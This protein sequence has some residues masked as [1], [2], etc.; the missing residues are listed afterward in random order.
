MTKH[1]EITAD[2]VSLSQIEKVA[3]AET[4]VSEHNPRFAEP[5]DPEDAQELA[6]TMVASGLIQNLSGLRD[7]AGK[8]GIVAGRRRWHA[9][10]IAV[11]ERPELA[12]IDVKVTDDLQT[13]LSWA[14]LENTKREEMDKVDEIRAYKASR[15]EGLSVAAIAKAYVETEAHVYRRLALADLPDP[16]LDALKAGDINL[17]HAKAFT[18]C[19]DAEKI[20]QVLE[21]ATEHYAWSAHQIKQALNDDKV[22]A[23]CRLMKFVGLEAYKAAGGTLNTNLFDEDATVADPCILDELARTK[24]V[25]QVEEFRAEQNL[26]WAMGMIDGHVNR[27][28]LIND[29]SYLGL[30][31]IP[32]ELSDEQQTRFTELDEGPWWQLPEEERAELDDLKAILEGDYSD[33][34]RAMSGAVVCITHAGKL[35]AVV[36]LVKKEDR[37]RAIEAGFLKSDEVLAAEAAA[38]EA[39]ESKA[40]E[41]A[42]SPYA[43]SFVEDMTAIRLAAFQTALLRKPEMVLD[44]LAFGLSRGSHW[45]T[46]TMAVGFDFQRNQPK[47]EDASFVLHHDL[48]GPVPSLDQGEEADD[49]DDHDGLE[50]PITAEFE[51]FVAGGKKPRNAEITRW[52]ARA[53]K[54]QSADFMSLISEKAGANMREVW[55]PTAANCFKRLKGWQLDDLFMELLE[56]DGEDSDFMAFKKLKKGQ[57]NEKMHELFHNPEV[58]AIYKVTPAQKARIDAWVP[59]CF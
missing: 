3:L 17:D 52:F 42:K 31:K 38:K 39:E 28:S 54:T 26:D 36:G 49:S 8:I 45:G 40:A 24:L 23:N 43:N 35:S 4:Y 56:R 47:D 37:D 14:M 6:K 33:E 57:K 19:D 46:E 41:A 2:A 7:E 10:Q 21:Q 44:L 22:D 11:Q 32:G 53:F 12:T 5:V 30:S 55:T 27:H 18:I 16:V 34:Q 48:G 25:E 29:G 1:A 58:Q 51:A 20:V 50:L 9:L 13:A 59:E 15:E